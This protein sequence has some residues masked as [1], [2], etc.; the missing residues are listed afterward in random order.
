MTIVKLVTVY[1][2]QSR[3][4]KLTKKRMVNRARRTQRDTDRI[5]YS[6]IFNTINSTLAKHGTLNITLIRV[7]PPSLRST[8]HIFLY[9]TTVCRSPMIWISPSAGNYTLLT[10]NNKILTTHALYRLTNITTTT[11]HPTQG[12][13]HPTQHIL[14]DI[15]SLTP[16]MQRRYW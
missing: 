13:T 6:K 7:T 11:L 16:V 10:H 4:S 9:S 3:I 12:N 1:K 5:T 2:P 15:I 8:A 14:L